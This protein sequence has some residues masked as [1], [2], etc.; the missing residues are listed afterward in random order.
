MVVVMN[1]ID[2]V[3]L[4]VA[5]KGVV[6]MGGGVDDSYNILHVQNAVYCPLSQ[7]CSP[8]YTYIRL[9]NKA[10]LNCISSD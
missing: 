6:R 5:R 3:L 10:T 2:V 8:L 4:I 7:I 9:Q 1:V